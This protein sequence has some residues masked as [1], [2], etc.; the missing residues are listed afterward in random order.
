MLS[1]DSFKLTD[2]F[3]KFEKNFFFL[4]WLLFFVVV[5]YRFLQCI[6]FLYFRLSVAVTV[7]RQK[8]FKKTD[9]CNSVYQC[10]SNFSLGVCNDFRILTEISKCTQFGKKKFV[11]PFP[12]LIARLCTGSCYWYIWFVQILLSQITAS[13][14]FA[15]LYNIKNQ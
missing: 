11:V 4:I 13:I 1:I 12:V 8:L 2:N 9:C 10:K 6:Y 5:T 7:L 15:I 3:K 14:K